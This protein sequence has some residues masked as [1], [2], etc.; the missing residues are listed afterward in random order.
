M[1]VWRL[2]LHDEEPADWNMAVDKA[3]LEAVLAGMVPP[4]LRLYRW[5]DAAIS[6]GRLQRAS[7]ALR[8]DV[9]R[10]I[11]IPVVRRPTGGRAILHGGDQVFSIAARQAEL[12]RDA[13]DVMGLYRLTSAGLRN[14][15][16][17]MGVHLVAGKRS[18]ADARSE[19]CFSTRTEADMLV[20]ESEAKLVGSAQCR[21]REA[22]LQ[23]TSIRHRRDLLDPSGLFR[24][25]II[26][27]LYPLEQFS[28]EQLAEQVVGSLLV[29]LN[30][31]FRE[32]TLCQWEVERAAALC[33]Q[34]RV[35]IASSEAA[36]G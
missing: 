10:A 8:V 31:R 6:L 30:A 16:A 18:L 14:A 17:Q 3:I 19:D 20:A 22:V 29:C 7:K 26:P 32:D 27:A 34:V 28:D 36:T 21:E 9:C 23:Q 5:R 35:P 13:R 12:P 24:T 1:S 4:T 11:G 33:A 2:I 25:P 15:F